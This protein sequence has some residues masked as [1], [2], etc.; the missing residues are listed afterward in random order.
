MAVTGGFIVV[1]LRRSAEYRLLSQE[2][3]FLV[4]FFGPFGGSVEGT[5]LYPINSWLLPCEQN[6]QGYLPLSQAYGAKRDVFR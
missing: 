1:A 5:A 4:F 3:W 2:F 6:C